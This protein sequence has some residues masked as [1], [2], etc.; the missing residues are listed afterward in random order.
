MQDHNIEIWYQL[1][2]VM[3]GYDLHKEAVYFFNKILAVDPG[4]DRAVEG[5]ANALEILGSIEEA[6]ECLRDYLESDSSA[7]YL[8]ILKGDLLYVH[9]KDH[10][11]A[12]DCYDQALRVNPKNEEAW[13][14]K[15]YALKQMGE[16]TA[17]ATSFKI[18]MQLFDENF[19]LKSLE[20]Y[21]EL[22]EEYNDCLDLL[23][24]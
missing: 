18:A 7:I 16:Y 1:A 2:D 22:C 8:W 9:H 6:L 24:D 11:R 14:K 13:T 21:R 23:G 10:R 20:Y 12:V 4:N 19:D 5:K 3:M 15:A 17:A